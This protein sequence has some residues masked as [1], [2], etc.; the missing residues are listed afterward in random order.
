MKWFESRKFAK[1]L[2]GAIVLAAVAFHAG[3]RWGGPLYDSA[4]PVPP[5]EAS[6]RPDVAPPVA[7][8]PAPAAVVPSP[9][10]A[11]PSDPIRLL[12][13][14]A[15]FERQ[16][17]LLIGCNE[18]V[19]WHP[20][21]FVNIV[22]AAYP[23]TRLIGLVG[24]EEELAIGRRLIKEAHL[25]A[26]AITFVMLPMYTMWVRDY[27]PLFA[28]RSDG[29]IV[30]VDS[31][32]SEVDDQNERRSDDAAPKRLAEMLRLPVTEAAL[33]LEG[34]NLLTNGD[35]IC[36]S[37]TSLITRNA[38]R[39]QDAQSIGRVLRDS[40][41][42][43]SWVYLKALSGEPTGHADMFVT[44]VARNIAVVGQ[45]DPEADPANAKAMDEAAALLAGEKTSDGPMKV[46]RI[47]MP[48]NPDG[49]WRSYTNVIFANK[50]LLVPTYSDVDPALQKRAFAVYAE[51]LPDW[52]IVGI[53]ADSLT[54]K[55]GILHCIT[56][57][58]PA[59]VPVNEL[60]EPAGRPRLVE[61]DDTPRVI[62]SPAIRL[63]RAGRL[64]NLPDTPRQD[65]LPINEPTQPPPGTI[66]NPRYQQ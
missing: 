45:V 18:L 2:A 41:G 37:T 62:V 29:A 43:R 13:P 20:R 53:D 34:G 50:T 24:Q 28:R 16:S 38:G 21:V 5:A 56:M 15:E 25:P 47:P 30:T 9:A 49:H 14:A 4:A 10:A 64:G 1:L 27:G 17:A 44:F 39:G 51:L 31:D 57:N 11:A 7:E 63:A 12:P 54:E 3:A 61:E 8:V 22:S 55:R 42:F 33:H 60:V 6:A 52:K 23:T 58:V 32:Y 46:H 35:G 19:R 36:V 26:S 59:F 65:V 40:F 48:P 66:L